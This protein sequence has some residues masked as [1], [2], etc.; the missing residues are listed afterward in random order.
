MHRVLMALGSLVLVACLLAGCR[1][2]REVHYR[3]EPVSSAGGG[4]AGG[5]TAGPALVGGAAP[6]Q[7]VGRAC[8]VNFRRDALGMAGQGPIE[9][10]ATSFARKPMYLEGTV[11]QA[12]DTWLVLRQAGSTLWI[13]TSAI[14]S[15]DLVEPRE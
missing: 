14:L 2:T 6:S 10:G 15:I 1:V 5:F 13:P 7:I 8:R 12:S 4:P 11:E 3:D 9:P